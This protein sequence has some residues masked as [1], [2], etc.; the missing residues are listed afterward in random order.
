VLVAEL[1]VA[2]GVVAV[3]DAGCL[4]ALYSTLCAESVAS[5]ATAQAAQGTTPDPWSL[6]TSTFPDPERTTLSSP[7]GLYVLSNSPCERCTDGVSYSLFL[8]DTVS[9]HKTLLITYERGVNVLWSPSSKA[10]IINVFDVADDSE[11]ILFVLSPQFKRVDLGQGLMK[12]SLSNSE[13]YKLS[14]AYPVFKYATGWL[15]PDTL[16]FK[17]QGFGE[18]GPGGYKDPFAGVYVYRIGGSFRLKDWVEPHAHHAAST[19]LK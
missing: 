9:R 17:V 2:A 12:V 7:D 15:G 13:R 6:P 8:L 16:L 4:S 3:A 18:A 11:S 14:H 10:L 1:S 19:S 5:K